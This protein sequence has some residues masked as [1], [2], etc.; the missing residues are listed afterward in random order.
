MKITVLGLIVM[1]L[2]LPGCAWFRDEPAVVPAQL[3]DFTEEVELNRLWR[4]NVGNGQ[5]G[6]YNRLM[7]AISGQTIY[8]ASNNGNII[9][10][11][12]ASGRRDWRYRAD[13]EITGGVGVSNS[14]VL[15]GTQD[16]RVIA[17]AQESGEFLWEAQVSSEV[18]SVPKTN[19]NIVVVQAIDGKLIG[20][21]A[22]SGNQIWLYESTVPALSLRGTSSPLILDNFVIAAFGNGTVVSVA[23]DNG[24]LRWEERVAIPTGRSE[25]DRL[26]DIDGELYLNDNGLLIVPSYQG[27][28]AAL[29]VTTGQIRWRV[30]ESSALGAAA[31]FGNIYI[32]DE[33]SHVKAYR[34]GQQTPVWTNEQ[35]FLRQLS[36]P[37]SFSNYVAV[38]DFE[39]YVHL[40]SQVDG[41]F[42]GRIKADSDGVRA[43]ILVRNNT[44]YVYGNSGRLSAL[45]IR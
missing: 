36:P 31:G 1:A 10:T 11:N 27:Y 21:D 6:K 17:L 30:E 2:A 20:L 8:A 9:A 29:E 19:G 34:T 44:L 23:L 35:L 14:L 12:L 26:I 32:C 25:I 41:R 42:V 45:G 28:L 15:V 4:V 5:G 18:L 24:T 40:L 39:G 13:A 33:R 43:P 16:S 38:G 37:T 3:E 22:Q 7:P